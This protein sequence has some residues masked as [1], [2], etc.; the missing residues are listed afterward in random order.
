MRQ[1]AFPRECM[2]VR[3]QAFEDFLEPV[4]AAVSERTGD[5]RG[6]V[7]QINVAHGI[8]RACYELV[9]NGARR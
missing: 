8:L 2:Q 1:A 5:R 3:D 9:S 7:L 4:L 6:D